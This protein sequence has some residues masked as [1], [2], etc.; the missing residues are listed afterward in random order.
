MILKNKLKQARQL[1]QIAKNI[2]RE[3]LEEII[4]RTA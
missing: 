1:E 4:E 3:I 2:Y